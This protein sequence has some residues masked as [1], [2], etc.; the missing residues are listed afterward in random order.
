MAHKKRKSKY[1]SFVVVSD[2]QKTPKNFRIPTL[3]LRSLFVLGVVVL[4]LIIVGFATYWQ[5][6]KLALENNRL[7]EDNFKLLQGLKQQEKIKEELAKIRGFES[8][9]KSSLSGYVSMQQGTKID[10][11]GETDFDF[12]KLSGEQ[13]QTIFR[14]VPSLQPTEGF[15][16]RGYDSS[17]LLAEPHYGL[18]ISAPTGTPVKAPADG[19]VV[20]SGWTV[21]GGNII[22]VEH[23]FGFTTVYKH[24]E[25]N[26]VKRLEKVSQGQTIALV[27]NT[28]K[29]SSGPHLHYEIWKNGKPMDP[30]KYMNIKNENNS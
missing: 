13:R 19:L 18:D 6:A 11:T 22:I 12:A 7:R 26:L 21:D 25:R 29:I 16:A 2:N 28:G 14:N 17:L 30:K 4:T 15:F 10:T 9:I 8:Q 20:Y 23:G 5:V 24:N 27:G 1:V 3:L